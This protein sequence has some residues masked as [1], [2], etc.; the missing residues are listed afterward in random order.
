MISIARDRLTA[1]E[2]KPD[3]E[4]AEAREAAR[5]KRT[6][7]DAGRD[8]LLEKQ[9]EIEA[10]LKAGAATKARGKFR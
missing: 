1:L 8:P 3:M 10:Q 6:L 7:V 4:L 2:V 5:A 9:N